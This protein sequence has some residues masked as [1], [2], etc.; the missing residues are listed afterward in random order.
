MS[1]AFSRTALLLGD[2]AMQKLAHAKVAVFGVGGV[3][4]FGIV[5]VVPVAWFAVNVPRVVVPCLIVSVPS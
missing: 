3:G 4:G 5:T 2:E 1:E